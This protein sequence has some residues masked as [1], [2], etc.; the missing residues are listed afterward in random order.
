MKYYILT[1]LSVLLYIN[2]F[3]QEGLYDKGPGNVEYKGDKYHVEYY[4]CTGWILYSTEEINPKTL[5][6][7]YYKSTSWGFQD[8]KG[9]DDLM[10][11]FHIDYKS[12]TLPKSIIVRKK[13]DITIG[14]FNPSPFIIQGI[15]GET[16]LL[17]D[18][19]N[20][21]NPIEK[22]RLPMS[23]DKMYGSEYKHK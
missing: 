14:D 17:S 11:R 23:C 8:E 3:S 5:L 15:Q 21:Y 19:Q 1:I 12:D 20:D 6:Y 18:W 7:E 9:S 22:W 2:S 13:W 4:G 16:T 10:G